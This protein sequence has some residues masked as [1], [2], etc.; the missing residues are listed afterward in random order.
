MPNG[1]SQEGGRKVAT[2]FEVAAA[3]AIRHDPDWNGGNYDNNPT[4]YIYSGRRDHSCRERRAHPTG[5]N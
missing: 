1:Y 5:E 3:E 2:P 4:R